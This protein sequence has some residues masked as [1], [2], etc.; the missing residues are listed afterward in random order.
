[1]PFSQTSPRYFSQ[2]VERWNRKLSSSISKDV[3]ANT[4]SCV[5]PLSQLRS[6][7]RANQKAPRETEGNEIP[8]VGKCQNA[9]EYYKQAHFCFTEDKKTYNLELITVPEILETSNVPNGLVNL[10]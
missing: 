10:I 1:M 4:N 3:N 2:S 5:N 8:E 6:P 7:A 9:L